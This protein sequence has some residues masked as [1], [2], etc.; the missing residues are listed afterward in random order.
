MA[1]GCVLDA[2]TVP[3]AEPSPDWFLDILTSAAPDGVYRS[4]EHG[5]PLMT[6]CSAATDLTAG[7]VALQPRGG[8][9]VW[10][11]L[12]DMAA[13]LPATVASDTR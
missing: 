8:P 5:D 7:T 1:R 6:L 2:V 10:L 3:A 12:A 11:P 13:G 4:A 9:R